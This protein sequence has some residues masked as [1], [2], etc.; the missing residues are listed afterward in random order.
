MQW[1]RRRSVDRPGLLHRD[2][3]EVREGVESRYAAFLD[4]HGDQCPRCPG[5]THRRIDIHH[6]GP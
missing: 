6:V 5:S 1:F 4:S 3:E 2:A